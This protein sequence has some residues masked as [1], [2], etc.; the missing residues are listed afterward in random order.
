M[1]GGVAVTGRGGARGITRPARSG[2][3]EGRGHA[4]AASARE[5]LALTARGP[6]APK[7]ADGLSAAKERPQSPSAAVR[8]QEKVCGRRPHFQRRAGGAG[9]AQRP[10]GLKSAAPQRQRLRGVRL[11]VISFARDR[12]SMAENVLPAKRDLRGFGLSP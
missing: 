12:F 9:A 7:T 2:A 5:G 1:S 3:E 4:A 8:P 10:Q 6:Q 11:S